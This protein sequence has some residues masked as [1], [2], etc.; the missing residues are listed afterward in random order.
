V[1]HR[2]QPGGLGERWTFLILREAS[3]AE[4]P[5]RPG[6]GRVVKDSGEWLVLLPGR[7][8]AYITAEA[9]KANVARMA[10][11]RQAAASPGAPERGLAAG[12]PGAL[13]PVR[14]APHDR[15]LPRRPPVR[16]G[17]AQLHVLVRES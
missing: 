2:S 4:L 17:H 5:G 14:R 13:R 1:R 16:A 11:N 12:R 3:Q 8:P 6:T 9:H 15:P 10:A 7:L